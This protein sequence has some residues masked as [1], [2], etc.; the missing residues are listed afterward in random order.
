MDG[1]RTKKMRM[2]YICFSNGREKSQ[3]RLDIFQSKCQVPL[4]CRLEM[5]SYVTMIIP[6]L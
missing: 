2:T 3:L 6:Q 4:L 1:E 5:N